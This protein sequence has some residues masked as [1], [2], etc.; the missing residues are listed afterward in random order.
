MNFNCLIDWT[1][2]KDELYSRF[3]TKF[4]RDEGHL[5]VSEPFA[6]MRHQGMILGPDGKKMRRSETYY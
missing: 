5:D 2:V 1:I 3:F 6:K 4:L